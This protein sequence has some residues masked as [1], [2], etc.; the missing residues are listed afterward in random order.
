MEYLFTVFILV[1]VAWGLA[2]SLD[3]A[4][5]HSRQISL[6]H[7]AFW[8]LGAYGYGLA[9]R[10]GL[11]PAAALAVGT[12][13]AA[14][15]GLVVGVPALRLKADYLLISTLGLG[16]L[17]NAALVNVRSVTGGSNGLAAIPGL[18]AGLDGRFLNLGYAVVFAGAAALFT[19]VAVAIRRSPFGQALRASAE[20]EEATEALG[21]FV[22]SL[23][24]RALVLGASL[25]G[26]LG[27]IYAAWSSFV[28]PALFNTSASIGILAMVL[29][30]GMGNP[31]G[32]GAG[33]AVLTMFPE[34]LRFVGL[35]GIN[36]DILRQLVYGLAL[37]ALM[38]MRP[39]GLFPPAPGK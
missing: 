10:A 5:G 23:R 15:G 9:A 34:A 6:A 7:A 36:A 32:A 28:S 31:W 26:A 2:V 17:V 29:L 33:A 3:I 18:A 38:A 19:A 13:A 16:E 8:G 20:D 25:A 30:G 35:S 24:L 14:A 1:C 21:R 11:H 22:T 4:S 37:V 27:G 12:V 39:G